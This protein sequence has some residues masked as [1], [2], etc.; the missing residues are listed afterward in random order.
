MV[1]K[2]RARAL[3]CSILLMSA[4]GCASGGSGTSSAGHELIAVDWPGSLPADQSM[5]DGLPERVDGLDRH[6]PVD[7]D[8]I[9]TDAFEILKVRYQGTGE[10]VTLR[11]VNLRKPGMPP[12][13]ALVNLFLSTDRGL[14]C[15]PDTY[16]GSVDAAADEHGGMPGPAE[17]Q[18]PKKGL[19]WFSC[20]IP[21]P[22]GGKGP[23]RYVV[24]WFKGELVWLVI[25]SSAEVVQQL[26]SELAGVWPPPWLES[27]RRLRWPSPSESIGTVG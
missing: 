14:R 24:G 1:G 13:L 19:A 2:Y 21:P 8:V 26:I 16:Q 4:T 15:T 7:G 27:P 5:L 18:I 6:R 22:H 12:R 9:D 3:V 17:D 20:Q 11:M 25:G 23:Q 10:D